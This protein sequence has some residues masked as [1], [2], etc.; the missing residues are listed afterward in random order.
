MSKLSVGVLSFAA[1]T[2]CVFLLGK[3]I[4]ILTQSA[5]AA[6]Q[7]AVHIEGAVPGVPPSIRATME[8]ATFTGMIHEVDGTACD[9]CTFKDVTFKYGGGA[10]QL[11]NSVVI[12]PV[13]IELSGAA[14]NTAAFLNSFGLIGCP[15]KV[16]E[17]PPAVIP[18]KPKW[19]IHLTQVTTT[20]SV[21]VHGTGSGGL[22]P[23]SGGTRSSV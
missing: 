7:T 20:G 1:G 10:Y 5:L 6:A 11:T 18:N 15:A 2:L 8:Q 17:T 4:S 12:P 13:R 21:A 14:A 23:D 9:Q 16:P 19:G 22:S 3:Q